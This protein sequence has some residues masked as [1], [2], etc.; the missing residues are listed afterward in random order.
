M[1][2]LK[3]KKCDEDVDAT[4]EEAAIS[5]TPD[6]CRIYVCPNC[7]EEL[8]D[9]NEIDSNAAEDDYYERQREK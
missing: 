8:G 5:G 7:G 1:V 2:I 6:T 4:A 9:A 3:C